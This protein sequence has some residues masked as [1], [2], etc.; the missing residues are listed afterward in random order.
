MPG[1]SQ[2]AE[3]LAGL[4]AA[5]ATGVVLYG[6]E[7]VVSDLDGIVSGDIGLSLPG[8][9]IYAAAGFDLRREEFKFDGDQRTDPRVVFNAP[10]DQANILDDV[11]RDIKA[12]FAELYLPLFESLEVTLAEIGRASGRE[13]MI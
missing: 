1:Q 11:S 10:F 9:A 3:A 7:S 8:G 5:S 12:V 13:R 2:S 6:G 4:Q